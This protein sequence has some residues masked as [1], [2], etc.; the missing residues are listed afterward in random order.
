MAIPY[1]LATAVQHEK[2]LDH[3]SHRRWASIVWIA[4]GLYLYLSAPRVSLFSYSAGLFFATGVC[5]AAIVVGGFGYLARC[6]LVFLLDKMVGLPGRKTQVAIMLLGWLLLAS[7]TLV[8]F[9]I[10]KGIF[11]CIRAT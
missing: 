1:E 4:S 11:G 10:A 9:Q 5:T 2:T 3:S 7:E 8:G 6:T